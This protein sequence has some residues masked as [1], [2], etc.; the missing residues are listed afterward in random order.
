MLCYTTTLPLIGNWNYEGLSDTGNEFLPYLLNN[1][2]F[3]GKKVP[4]AIM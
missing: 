4:E 1:S 2:A 3:K